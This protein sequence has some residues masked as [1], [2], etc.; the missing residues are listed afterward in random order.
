MKSSIAFTALAWVLSVAAT[1][2]PRGKPYYEK[3]EKEHCWPRKHLEDL[4]PKYIESFNGIT[5]GGKQIKEVFDPE[6]KLYSQSVWWVIGK[7]N[8]VEEHAK[9]DD[10]PPV[11]KNRGEFL[12]YQKT[13]PQ[14]PNLI[15]RGKIAYGCNTFSFYW[16]GD[17]SVPGGKPYGRTNGLDMVFLNPKTAKVQ[18][19]YSEY[20]TLNQVYNWGSHITWSDNPVCCECPVVFDPTCRCPS[21]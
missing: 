15:K 12:S 13:V 18:L 14:Q 19:A 9:K 20:N 4:V 10:F 2:E 21:K 7:P 1:N 8:V 11:W 5:D 3:P 6:F 16:K 17:F